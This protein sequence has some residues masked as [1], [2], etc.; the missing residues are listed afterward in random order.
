MSEVLPKPR[1]TFELTSSLPPEEIARRV[2]HF[3]RS[4]ER[5]KGIAL[6]NRLELAFAR[7]EQHLWSPQVIVDVESGPEGSSR[8]HSR[9][10]PHPH[11]W[12]MY[13]AVY[14]VLGIFGLLA[15]A[16]GYSQHTLGES[17][18]AL[19][20]LPLLTVLAALTYGVP[21][22]GQGLGFGQMYQLRSTLEDLVEAHPNADEEGSKAPSLAS[23]SSQR[24]A[25]RV[26]LSE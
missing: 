13:T 3:L 2:G 9:F 4:N 16:Y 19:Y 15:M 17:P 21:F 1:P 18:S 20:V 5:I 22:I 7:K 6:V 25:R 24:R 14:F 23:D 12:T 10:G 11:V 26:V 8:L